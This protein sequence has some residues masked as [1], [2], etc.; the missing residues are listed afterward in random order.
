MKKISRNVVCGVLAVLLTASLSGISGIE[1]SAGSTDLFYD[2]FESSV[3]NWTARGP[4]TVEL[5]SNFANKGS[6]SLFVSG[7]TSAWHGA[8]LPLGDQFSPGNTY[9]FG[10]MIMSNDGGSSEEIDMTMQYTDPSG[11]AVYDHMAKVDVP[12]GEWTEVSVPDYTVPSGA[13]NLILYFETPENTIDFYV[14]DVSARL[15]EGSSQQ[16]VSTSKY[17]DINKDEKKDIIDLILIK[18]G[19]VDQSGYEDY[20]ITADLDGSGSVDSADA[21]LLKNYLFGEINKFPSDD[22]PAEDDYDKNYKENV[23]ADVLKMYQDSL[24]S[25]GNTARTLDKIKK[26]KAGEKITIGYIGGS[27]TEGTSAGP[28]LCYAKR[29]YEYFAQTFGTGNNVS[30]VNAGLSGTSS[31]LGV[32]R[33]QRDLLSKKPDIIFIEYSVNDQGSIQYQ[34]AYEALTKKCLMQDNDPAVIVLVTRSQSG[35]SCQKQMAAVAKNYDLPVISVDNAISN[36]LNSG[37][38]TWG[39]YASDQFHPHV[40]G[41]QLVADFIGYYY[42]QAQLSKNRSTSY[43]IPTTT[44]YGDEYWTAEMVNKSEL[45]NFNPGSFRNGTSIGAFPDGW[46]NSKNGNTPMTFTTQ[47]KGIFIM[48]K[49]NQS[50]MGT[51]V[52]N[53]NGK[54]SKVSGNKLY[55]WG[56]PDADIAYIQD[57]V[58]TLKVSVSMESASSNFEILGIG[59]VK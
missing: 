16:P 24:Y 26:A 20:K 38:M 32:L 3:G 47:G 2:T 52:V 54:Q 39:D 42:R 30:Y 4:A 45:I 36:A 40:K 46:T 41:H 27:I 53:V 55:T 22:K 31:V 13:S 18:N 25:I 11:T 29:S 49:S 51:V 28:S 50:G 17:G 21:V 14:D 1:C 37:K 15:A 35:G 48:F 5:S 19:L 9:S 10:A 34:K 56:G 23:S 6:R 33:A 7:R 59:V 8:S 12:K 58:D 57:N 43:T 44:V